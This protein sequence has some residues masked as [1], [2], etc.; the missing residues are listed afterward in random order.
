MALSTRSSG[1]G[2]LSQSIAAKIRGLKVQSEPP[3]PL[4]AQE[5]DDVLADME[6]HYPDEIVNLYRFAFFSGLR[7]SELLALPARP[8]FRPTGWR[9]S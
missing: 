9:M 1:R 7:T 3:D 4:S 6:S 8:M 2:H 5:R